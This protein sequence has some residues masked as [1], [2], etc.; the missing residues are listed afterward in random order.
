MSIIPKE[1]LRKLIKK[2]DLKDTEDIQGMLKDMF[3]DAIQEMLEAELEEDLGYSR[4]DYKNK[5]TKN[6]RNG[7]SKKKVRSNY[8][9]SEIKIPRDRDGEFSPK[10][11]KKNQTTLPSIDD[12]VLSM[13]AKGMTT[14]DIKAHLESIYGIDASP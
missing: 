10:I 6:S 3:G 7:F 4:Y 13:Y 14:R 8:G 2:Y 1:E 9:D 5:T 11:V 12:Q